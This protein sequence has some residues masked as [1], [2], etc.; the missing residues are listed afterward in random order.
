MENPT[1]IPN[2]L[3]S[4]NRYE[5]QLTEPSDVRPTADGWQVPVPA[6]N[7]ATPLDDKPAL[8][9]DL[10]P[11]DELTG[12]KSEPTFIVDI[13]MTTNNVKDVVVYVKARVE[14]VDEVPD[15]AV[16]DGGVYRIPIPLGSVGDDGSLLAPINAKVDEV[17]VILKSPVD[18]DEPYVLN[19]KVLACVE[20]LTT[21]TTAS[22]LAMKTTTGPSTTKTVTEAV[23]TSETLATEAT[24]TT[25]G[26][27]S[28]V[29]T[30]SGPTSSMTCKF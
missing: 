18:K 7:D 4:G 30:T 1:A 22:T 25:K 8:T 14:F 3:I 9:I 19:V 20:Y 10:S 11:V 2:D 16:L 6:D 24:T 27:T 15:G 28:Q 5:E 29:P 13:A 26:T 12:E 21:G 23:T 17:V